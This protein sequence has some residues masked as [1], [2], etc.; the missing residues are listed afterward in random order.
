M[1]V[2]RF[3]DVDNTGIYLHR[4]VSTI[5]LSSDVDSPVIQR[6]RY[7]HGIVS[8][9][10]YPVPCSAK[11]PDLIVKKVVPRSHSL[12]FAHSCFVSAGTITKPVVQRHLLTIRF[13][14]ESPTS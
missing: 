5:I 9:S 13:E 1:T 11:E 2:E 7:D 6:C 8:D 4:E 3:Q 12:C 14:P 10:M